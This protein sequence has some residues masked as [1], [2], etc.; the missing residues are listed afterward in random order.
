[1]NRTGKR[2]LTAGI[3]LMIIAGSGAA[4]AEGKPVGITPDMMSINVTHG[5]KTV[6]L[7]RNQD[8]DAT[9]NPAFAKTSRPCPPFCIQPMVL[10]PGV[11][12]LGEVE[13]INYISKMEGG[14]KNI[15]L[16]DSRTPDWVEK[17]T[18]P[19]AKNISWVELTPKK[20]AT[21]EGI[22][23]IMMEDFNVALAGDADSFTVDEAIADGDTSKVFDY[24][25]AKTL[26]LFCNG[27]WCG[28]SPASI[29]TLLKF[30][31]PADKIKWYRD[32]MQS[33]EVLG[34]T[35]VKP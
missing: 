29:E 30:G 14:D 35:T 8:N 34:L 7:M 32:G 26:V 2:L 19:G 9:V 4:M 25:N 5:G 27:M 1:M 3:S 23:K 12:T 11:E 15:I 33:W 16:I 31:Y 6:E 20:G 10:A 28:Q 18:I 13:V 21:T 17:G 22:M 24:S